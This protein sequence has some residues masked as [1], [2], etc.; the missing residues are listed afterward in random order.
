MM[1]GLCSSAD[2]SWGSCV[3]LRCGSA[4]EQRLMPQWYIKITDYADRLIDDLKELDWP[5]QK[6][7]AQINWIGR[8]EL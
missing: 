5:K 6:K 8:F 2:E 1:K 4:V 7:D 3:R